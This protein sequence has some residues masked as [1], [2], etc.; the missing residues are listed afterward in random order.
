MMLSLFGFLKM[1]TLVFARMKK[2]THS[3]MLH[4][5]LSSSLL[6]MENTS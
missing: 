2:M 4:I 5:A 1:L 3:N 6:Q